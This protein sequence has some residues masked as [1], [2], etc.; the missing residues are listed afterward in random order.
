MCGQL[1]YNNSAHIYM[2]SAN[3]AAVAL[4]LRPKCWLTTQQTVPACTSK[5]TRLYAHPD[6]KWANYTLLLSGLIS[7]RYPREGH[8]IDY[9]NC[10]TQ[11]PLSHKRE[12]IFCARF[13]YF[14]YIWLISKEALLIT[15]YVQFLYLHII[16][17]YAISFCLV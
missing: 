17:I 5:L 1:D 7:I 13:S 3:I 11:P 2:K 8:V 14:M 10:C 12:D 4:Q 6:P 9:P 15:L 16:L